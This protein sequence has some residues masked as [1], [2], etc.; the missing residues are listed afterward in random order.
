MVDGSR[1][2]TDLGFKAVRTIKEAVH[3]AVDHTAL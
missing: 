3:A 2:R 1:A